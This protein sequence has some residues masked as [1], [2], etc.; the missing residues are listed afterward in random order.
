MK[1]CKICKTENSDNDDIC[2]YCGS[3]LGFSKFHK[4][5]IMGLFLWPVLIYAIYLAIKDSIK[6]K[7]IREKN[8]ISITD[9][10]L[11]NNQNV[12][13]G[14][15]ESKDKTFKCFCVNP[16]EHV[17]R[18]NDGNLTRG[19]TEIIISDEFVTIKQNSELV[20]YGL[21]SIYYFGIWTYEEET[22]FKF[23]MRNLNEYKFRDD[24]KAVDNIIDILDDLEV[25]IEDDRD[26]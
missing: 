6:I 11:K 8:N 2:K 20:K 21:N 9:L 19:E 1:K 12:N 24:N 4:V 22:Y 23:R 17:H 15:P 16:D 7:E 18:D 5:L 3:Y 13:I 14:I 25:K 10:L 26:D